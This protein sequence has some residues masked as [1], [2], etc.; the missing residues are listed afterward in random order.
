MSRWL[1]RRFRK[2]LLSSQSGLT[3]QQT[4]LII[5]ACTFIALVIVLAGFALSRVEEKIKTDVGE[6]LQIVLQ[7]TRESLNLWIESNKFDLTRL[8][9]D[10]RIIFLAEH[11]LQVP[12]NKDDLLKSQ[13]LRDLRIFFEINKDRFGKANYFIIAP[14]FVNIAS[15]GDKNLGSKNRIASQALDLLNRAFKGEA[16]MVPPIWSDVPLSTSLNKSP[17]TIPTMFFAAPIKNLQGQIIATVARQV[18]PSQDFTRLIQLGRIGKTGETYAFGR[19]G[20]LLSQSRF[21]E[22]LR[23]AGLLGEGEKSILSVGVRDPGGDMT[24]GFFPSVPRYQQ[25]LTLMAEQATKGK[26]GLNV[27]GYR[28]YRGVPVHGAWLWDDKLGV[29]LAT[30]IDQA[31]AL[32]PYFTTRMVILT[33]L[34]ITVLLALGSLMF[35]V[36]IDVRANRALQKSY[37]ELE[38]RVEERTTELKENQARLEQ[39]EERS[40]L[41]LESAEEGIFGVG[42]DGL[43]NFI[44]PA[45]LAMLSF[46]ADEL[47]GQKIHELIHHTRTDGTPYPIEECPM[48]H[49]LTRGTIGS[50]DDEVLWRKDGTSFPVEYTSVPIRKN[51]NIAGTVVVFRDISERKEAEVA[52]RESRATARGLLDATQESLLLLDSEGILIAVNQTAA[53]RHQKTPEELIGTNRFDILPQNLR[54]SRKAH[55]NNVLQTG[56]PEDFEDERD[57]MVLHHIYYPVQD[58]TGAIIGVAIFAQDITERKHMEEEV[59]RNVEELEQFSKLAIGRE[60]KMIQLKE[61]INELLGQLDQGEKYEIVK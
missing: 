33:V 13:T 18:D 11:Q 60:V 5:L 49:S 39:A 10:P 2:D 14:D 56:N 20:K 46:E 3:P 24:K 55:F 4:I 29:G 38:L 32:G 7:T 50:R 36:L 51:G 54:E 15:M 53:R 34:G 37:D 42:E 19:Y 23:K 48:H 28:D 21:D 40:R 41:L 9:G 59:K 30:E 44:N 45:G 57:G 1:S 52:L 47:I 17:K 8:A 58:K 6:A 43:V 31:D 61:E 27:A 25:P 22:D 35:A 12:R 26:S 16:I